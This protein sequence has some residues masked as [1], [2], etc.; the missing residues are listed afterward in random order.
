MMP[1]FI[2]ICK[3]IFTIHCFANDETSHLPGEWGNTLAYN[4][5]IPDNYS[6]RNDW[7][8]MLYFH[9]NGGQGIDGRNKPPQSSLWKEKV[10]MI[11]PQAGPT[12]SQNWWQKDQ[13]EAAKQ[14]L[15]YELGRLN[16]NINKI[17][18]VGQSMGG[19][20][21]YK[22]VTDYPDVPSAVAPISGGWG[23]FNNGYAATSGYPNDMERF[24]HIPFWIFHGENDTIVRI[25][26]AEQAYEQMIQGG[27]HVKFTR[28]HN[29]GHKPRHHVYNNQMFYDW[30]FSQEKGTPHN[31]QLAIEIDGQ[32]QVLG[33][34]ES[35]SLIDI[36]TSL[37]SLENFKFFNFWSSSNGISYQGSGGSKSTTSHPTIISGSFLNQNDANTQFVMGA[38]DTIIIPNYSYMPE[39]DLSINDTNVNSVLNLNYDEHINLTIESSYDLINWKDENIPN[40][41]HLEDLEN[42]KFYRIKT[43]D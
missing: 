1:T 22:F 24:S 29:Q 12:M 42:R 16:V 9:G 20:G 36:S 18:I 40:L 35:G 14:I 31:Y 32:L 30:A 5:S 4:V 8:V 43:L 15:D 3:T 27:I 25:E 38:S 11:A 6:N 28:Y 2:F 21:S 26:C 13:R 19:Y 7:P 10:V 17:L 41:P 37:N 34:Y 33:Y 23:N 39:I